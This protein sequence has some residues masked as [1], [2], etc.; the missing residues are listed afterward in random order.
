M[1]DRRVMF[2][3]GRKIA[4]KPQPPQ[5]SAK[6]SLGVDGLSIY[7]GRKEINPKPNSG[8]AANASITKQREVP[9]ARPNAPPQVVAASPWSWNV[10]DSATDLQA[11]QQ[12]ERGW[13]ERMVLSRLSSPHTHDKR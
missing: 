1:G 11:L 5:Q 12:Q 13:S 4:L 9:G 2:N 6:F 8:I 10:P 3:S 7:A